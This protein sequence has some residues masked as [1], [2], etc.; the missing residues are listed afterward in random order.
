MRGAFLMG[1]AV[2][3]GAVCSSKIFDIP[4]SYKRMSDEYGTHWNW[5]AERV[6]AEF[7]FMTVVF[8]CSLVMSRR[9]CCR[10]YVIE[11]A[12]GEEAMRIGHCHCHEPFEG[13]GP[14]WSFWRALGG[15]LL[16]GWM[17]A[18][19]FLH[20]K[21]VTQSVLRVFK[22]VIDVQPLAAR[23]RRACPV[24]CVESLL[25]ILHRLRT[26]QFGSGGAL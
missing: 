7:F 1:V 13:S 21:G 2:C 19:K 10:R 9:F 14:T 8:F 12:A 4:H 24:S 17:F 20:L 6:C 22:P 16:S 15:G 23:G 25:M 26:A 18:S 3:C 11:S 5:F